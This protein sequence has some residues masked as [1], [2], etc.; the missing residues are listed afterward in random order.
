MTERRF[1]ILG[2]IGAEQFLAEYWQRKP[3]LIRNALPGFE[4]PLDPDELAGLSLEEEIESRIVIEEGA[5]CRW[6]LHQG[7]FSEET[8]RQLPEENWT[9]LVQAVDLWLPEV[10]QLLEHFTFLPPWRVDDIM[11]SYAPKGGSVGPHFDYYDVF[12]LQGLGQR[13]WQ[14]GGIGDKL[15]DE[16]SPRE[17]DTA[18]RILKDYPFEQ[19]WVL[20]PG[21]MLYLPPQVAHWGTALGDCITYSIGFRAPSAAEMLSDLA[22]ELL[23]QSHSPHYKDPLLTPAMA[24]EQISSQHIAQVRELLSSVLDDEALLADWFARYM[25]TPKY[26]DLT[27]ISGESRRAAVNGNRYQ[28]GITE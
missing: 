10:K 22:N 25:T 4:S 8:F 7:P 26:A 9:L 6:E 1:P 13:H 27:D 15:C 24:C 2:E 23:S 16:Q 3:L 5:S 28:N 20:E 18:L 21:D 17:P 12:L 11:V 19:E 14:I